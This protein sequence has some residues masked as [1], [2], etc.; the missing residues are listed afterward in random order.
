MNRL[1]TTII[2]GA[3]ALSAAFTLASA[4]L[5]KGA[6]P[7]LWTK[8]VAV[9]EANKY[10]VPGTMDQTMEELDGDGAVKSRTVSRYTFKPDDKGEIDMEVLSAVKDGKDITAQERKDLAKEKAKSAERK[11][12]EETAKK[13]EGAKDDGESF[14]FGSEDSPFNPKFQETLSVTEA[15]LRDTVAGRSC[16]VF[17]FAYTRP[18]GKSAKAKPVTSKGRVWIEEETGYPVRVDAT[19]EPLPRGAKLMRSS[20]LYERR[21]GGSCVLKEMHFEGAGGFLF[22]K[23][24]MRFRAV[25]DNFWLYTP[26]DKSQ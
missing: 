7:E 19:P 4:A 17:E 11:A 5:P 16:A 12:K 26:P 13:K 20:I 1:P 3:A 9:F 23:K 24:H 6:I 2:I 14:S 10:V 22:I 21:P 8:A 25:F 18:G 15:G